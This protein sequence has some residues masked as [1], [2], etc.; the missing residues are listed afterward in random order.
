VKKGEK[1]KKLEKIRSE[2][3]K[4]NLGLFL[5]FCHSQLK[6]VEAKSF[7]LVNLHLAGSASTF[8]RSHADMSAQ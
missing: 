5:I 4:F 7:T 8:P 2:K 1:L 6:L 3:C